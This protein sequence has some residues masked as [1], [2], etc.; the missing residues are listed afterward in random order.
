M[1]G[2]EGGDGRNMSVAKHESHNALRSIID[3]DL[4]KDPLGVQ[5]LIRQWNASRQATSKNL[6]ETLTTDD[7][8]KNLPAEEERI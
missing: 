7:S 6:V 3:R 2:V 5:R 4:I 8:G 1:S